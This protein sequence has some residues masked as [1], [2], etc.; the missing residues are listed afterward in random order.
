M[1]NDQ[2]PPTRAFKSTLGS[3]N[4]AG[5]TGLTGNSLYLHVYY[6]I[7]H[8][9][10]AGLSYLTVSSLLRFVSKYMN[11]RLCESSQ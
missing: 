7:K 8:K 3:L 1:L 5:K 4:K 6:I 11:V 2:F 10:L 9:A